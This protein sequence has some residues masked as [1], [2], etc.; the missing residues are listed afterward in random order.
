MKELLLRA[1]LNET[2]SEILAFLLETGPA[3]GSSI[4]RR[5]GIKRT[6]VYSSLSSLE[7]LGLIASKKTESASVF[8]ATASQQIPEMLKL[9]AQSEFSEVALACKLLETDLK[10]IRN[11]PLKLSGGL[12][13]TT[14]KG[15][16]AV[17][18]WLVD[19]FSSYGYDSIFN[20]Q[21]AFAG[22]IKQAAK[23]YLL[24][25]GERSMP[26]REIVVKGPMA[27]WWKKQINNPKHL[28]KEVSLPL[29]L[30]TDI[31]LCNGTVCMVNY[32]RQSETAILIKH[33]QYYASMQ[34]FF[35]AMWAK[36]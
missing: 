33:P 5:T 30:A 8:Q 4:A 2:E 18:A 7:R 35:E 17:Y 23:D 28:L 22:P 15:L 24:A 9:R 12:E 11:E 19:S 21:K 29:D 31:N 32:E 16:D 34:A 13:V 3:R 14:L 6:T 25:I 26:V 36:L 1:G 20:P 10:K 27:S